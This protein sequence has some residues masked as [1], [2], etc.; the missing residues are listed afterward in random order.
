[1]R[2]LA[3]ECS[4]PRNSLALLEDGV[5]RAAID[6]QV[7]GRD[8]QRLFD[9]LQQALADNAWAASDLDHILVGR[10]PGQFSG[11]RIS[12]ACARALA[13]PHR[14][15]VSGLP[16]AH[17]LATTHFEQSSHP[18]LVLGDA[19]RGMLWGVSYPD[20]ASILR[21]QVPELLAPGE[22]ADGC[23]PDSR[24]VSSEPDRVR[25]LLLKAGGEAG[26]ARLETA[27]P[28]AASLAETFW[29]D[30][31]RGAERL[32]ADP[33]YLHPPVALPRPHA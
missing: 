4:S 18:L 10:G 15:P 17:A 21:V 32:P 13:L 6:W 29:R 26:A 7:S 22:V 31:G 16:S 27:F 28:S 19:R 3:M 11:L 23:G 5:L 25:D 9:H 1:M 20:A 33:I 24:R 30:P 12:L 2:C 8:H 14:I